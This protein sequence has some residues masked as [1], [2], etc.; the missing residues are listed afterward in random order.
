MPPLGCE[1]TS[2]FVPH[3]SSAKTCVNRKRWKY[4]GSLTDH[5]IHF[6]E[7]AMM[8]VLPAK[9]DKVKSPMDL[10]RKAEN[11]QSTIN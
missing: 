6:N 8:W 1:S 5:G 10:A 9:Y 3:L 11:Q 4:G 7:Y 2:R